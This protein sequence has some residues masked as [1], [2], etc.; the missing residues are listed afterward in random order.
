MSPPSRRALTSGN[1][2]SASTA[3]LTKT[4]MKPSFTPCFFSKRSLY[5]VRKSM[6]FERSAS[7]KVVSVAVAFC[8]AS[9]RSAMRRRICDIGS[10][11]VRWLAAGRAGSTGCGRGSGAR[12][13]ASTSP[14]VT[15]PPGPVPG[16]SV[17]FRPDSVSKRVAAGPGGGTAAGFSGAFGDAAAAGG[18]ASVLI[19]ATTD[20]TATVAPSLASIFKTPAAGAGT[21]WVALSVPSSNSGSSTFT[22]APSALSQRLMVASVI[23][24]PARG[25]LTCSTGM[26][27]LRRQRARLRLAANRVMDHMRRFGRQRGI[28]EF[29][30]LALVGVVRAGGRAGTGVAAHI[31][32]REAERPQSRFHELP[33]THVLR[34]FL[35][36]EPLAGP[37]VFAECVLQGGL[38]PRVK[39]LEA[40]DGR[41]RA[42]LVALGE[43]IVID[44]AGTDEHSR[45]F[46]RVERVVD[47]FAEVPCGELLGGRS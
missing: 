17:A 39:L 43:Q 3:A 33:A 2:R 5:R 44:L 26:G 10:R 23:D 13:A 37:A 36:P 14:F 47:H 38:R 27:D 11:V 46:I 12:G 8:E 1:A 18:F 19:S 31:G 32:K 6:R 25:T 16:T 28:D 22:N 20:S 21:S 4:D 45:N 7:L 9:R 15:R 42:A 24:S 29:V 41:L 35:H 40:D 30:L 34:L